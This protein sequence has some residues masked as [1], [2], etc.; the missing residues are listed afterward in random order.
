MVSESTLGISLGLVAAFIQAL[1]LFLA[2]YL[3]TYGGINPFG[4]AFLRSIFFFVFSAP[5]VAALKTNYHHG[6]DKVT[7]FFQGLRIL[8]GFSSFIL[9]FQALTYLP[10]PDVVTIL[11]ASPIWA[12]LF[13]GFLLRERLFFADIFLLLMAVSGIAM[14]ARPAFL[15]RDISTDDPTSRFLGSVFALAASFCDASTFL[16]LRRLRSAHFTTVQF[17][18]GTGYLIL[19]SIQSLVLQATPIATC[20]DMRALGIAMSFSAVFCTGLYTF[21][22]RFVA[23]GILALI[24]STDTIFAFLLQL[25]I[26]NKLPNALSLVGVCLIITA[27]SFITFRSIMIEKYERKFKEDPENV[28]P[29]I[30]FVFIF[31]K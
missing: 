15:F 7:W 13:G 22:S 17:L 28:S 23:P 2:K 20:Y 30:R 24:R 9:T 29:A 25:V 3:L 31:L 4:A 27:L 21:C 26:Q 14:V 18:S 8:S 10:Q 1:S 19:T 5:L 16:L 11:A 6:K 12:T